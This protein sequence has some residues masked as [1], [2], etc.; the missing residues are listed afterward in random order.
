M[1]PLSRSLFLSLPPLYVRLKTGS[2]GHRA[3][4]CIVISGLRTFD[5]TSQL[6]FWSET[7]GRDVTVLRVS[8]KTHMHSIA[9]DERSR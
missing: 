2:H 1:I 9:C 7:P 4:D 6:A 5:H 8:M 3:Q